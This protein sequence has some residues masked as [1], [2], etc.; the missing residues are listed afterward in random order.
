MSKEDNK[1]NIKEEEKISG[2]KEFLSAHELQLYGMQFPKELE[3]MLY[4]KLKYEIFDISNYF[5]IMD[6]QDE[7]RYLLRSKKNIKKN[8]FICLIDHCW[9]Y[10]LRKFNYFCENFPNIIKRATSMLKY[11]GIRKPI[12]NTLEKEKEI[13]KNIDEYNNYLAANEEKQKYLNYDEY[14]I[15]DD[16]LNLLKINSTKTETL[17]IEDNKIQNIFFIE[18]ILEKNKNIKALWC[19]GNPFCEVNEEYEKDFENKFSNLEIINRKFTK[20]ASKWS[21]ELILDDSIANDDNKDKIYYKEYDNLYGQ[22]RFLDLSGRDPLNI[23]DYSIF[24][25][26][27]KYKILGIDITDND[28]DFSNEETKNKF[29]KFLEG[30]TNDLEYLT[31]DDNDDI[32]NMEESNE[33]DG[34][35]IFMDKELLKEIN[36]KIKYINGIS[37]NTILSRND[38][39]ENLIQLKRENYV[40]KYMWAINR[41]YRL[42]SEEKY[43]EDAIYYLNDEFG[44]SINHSDVPNCCLF[45]FIFAKNNKFEEDMITYSLLWPK[46]NINKGEEIF[47]DYLANISENEERSSRLTCWYKTPNNYFEKKFLDKLKSFDKIKNENRIKKF[48]EDINTLIEKDKNGKEISEEDLK[49]VFNFE[50]FIND[51]EKKIKIE[52]VYKKIREA[53]SNYNTK[54]EN[55]AEYFNKNFNKTDKKIKVCSDLSY[56]RDNLKF[57]NIELTNNVKEADIVWLNAN[58][59]DMLDYNGIIF[60]NEGK[61]VF[62]NQYPYESII[63]MK[64][65]LSNLIQNNFGINDILGLSYDM[66]TELAEIIGNYYYNEDKGYENI[67]ILK[68]IN[69]SR[70]MD[71]LITD[72][73][74]EIIR[75]VETGPKICQKYFCNP[76]L[77]NNKKFDLRFIIAVKSLLPLELYFYDKM[78]W[79]R[80]A[81]KDY[82]KESLSF[83]DYEVH[84]TVMNYS[85]FGMQTIYDKD[86]IKYLKERNIEWEPI[87]NKLK[88]KVKNVMLLACKDC[89]QMINYNSRAIYGLDAMIDDQFE[90]HI[91]EINYQ[92]DCTRACK[93]IPEFYNDIFSTLFF[94]KDSGMVKV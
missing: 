67:W 42:V 76:Y 34:Y 10:K 54:K 72:N 82:N 23:K 9:T 29:I 2:I 69:M 41:T 93:F 92:P 21:I 37:I 39:Y 22:R 26:V 68:P 32:F 80:S 3:E 30:F 43:D 8:E 50:L 60:K 59:F 56:V 85:K 17:S 71:M 47:I 6:N 44:S 35:N 77:M 58:I 7:N 73:L 11:A 65:Y 20:N 49:N 89:P 40:H 12:I 81:N 75:A 62:I 4:T 5:E 38:K 86:F 24:S 45:P 15:T 36:K 28:Y 57:E 84:F 46:K 51:K 25:K 74:K 1:E 19:S 31:V 63:T 70:S 13:K 55:S 79:I 33:Q 90:P 14:D 27:N 48:E 88:N 94:E 52:D 16:N 53:I 64:S 87:Y 83:D 66:R 78:F 91:I 18:D 61:H